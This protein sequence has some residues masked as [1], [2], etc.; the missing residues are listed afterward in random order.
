M[1]YYL[2][3]KDGSYVPI[4]TLDEANKLPKYKYIVLTHSYAE[5]NG[6]FTDHYL[7]Y[8]FINIEGNDQPLKIG[9]WELVFL[10]R[11][12][13]STRASMAMSYRLYNHATDTVSDF[14]RNIAGMDFFKKELFPKLYELSGISDYDGMIIRNQ[15]DQL[16][17]AIKRIEEKLTVN[18]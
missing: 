7:E 2:L 9:D 4:K 12:F 17:A 15:L 5:K 11:E 3:Y 8:K 14:K 13:V 1:S 18:S 16:I 6:V 10:S